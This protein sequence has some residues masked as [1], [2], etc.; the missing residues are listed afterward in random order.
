MRAAF[1]TLLAVLGIGVL[2]LLSACGGGGGSEPESESENGSAFS[3]T[4]TSKLAAALG[5]DGP[6]SIV[7][8]KESSSAWRD[9]Q[10]FANRILGE[11]EVPTL[12]EMEISVLEDETSGDGRTVVVRVL[13]ADL[14]A[15]YRISMREVGDQW[16]VT[17]YEVE[18]IV[19]AMGR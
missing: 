2:F 9:A 12:D 14:S 6:G 8:E 3:E 1:G 18:E 19:E 5:L 16:R 7:W 11:T 4:V 10:L 17:S 13:V 15:E